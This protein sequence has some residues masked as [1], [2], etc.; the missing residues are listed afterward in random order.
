MSDDLINQIL[1]H[2]ENMNNR[3]QGLETDISGIKASQSRLETT[4]AVLK[5]NVETVQSGTAKL[6]NDITAVK[7]SQLNL[8]N[9]LTVKVDALFDGWEQ[10]E[11]YAARST[12]HLAAIE[13]R[14]DRIDLSATKIAAVQGEHSELLNILTTASATHETEILALKRAK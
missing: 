3:L 6:E 13:K 8:E 14:L 4:M 11:D 5:T 10:H 1:T 2:L 12:E 9:N 7:T